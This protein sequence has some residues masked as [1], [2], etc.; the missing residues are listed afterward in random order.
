MKEHVSRREFMKATAI[1]AL[2][3]GAIGSGLPQSLMAETA[4]GG[5]PMRV[6]GKTGLKVT[7]LA[8][9]GWHIGR[10][11]EVSNSV[12]MLHMARDMGI[13]FF[14][15]AWEYEKGES[16]RRIGLA[17]K[18]NGRDKIYIMTKVIARDRQGAEAQLN[19]SLTRM[20]TDYLD[21]WQFHAVG[22]DEELEQIFGPNGACEVALKAKREGKIRHIGLTGHRD[23]HVLAKAAREYSDVI[24]T[25][26]FPVNVIDPHYLSFIKGT[27]P[28]AVKHNLGILAMKTC[29]I[30]LIPEAKIATIDE[31]LNFAWSQ[32]VSLVVSGMDHFDHLKH[33]IELAKN[34]RPMSEEEQMRLLART[35]EKFGTEYERYKIGGQKWRVY[36]ENPLL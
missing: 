36:P 32:P 34:F 31:C 11:A 17:F 5:I 33:N 21:L 29:A 20:Q 4:S 19:D 12:K 30:G 16:E 7:M 2:G 14:D 23:P 35:R 22:R 15:S 13:N 6:L 28:E 24:E 10:M 9:P 1:G 8:A 27:I 25:L 26:Q 18:N 3:I